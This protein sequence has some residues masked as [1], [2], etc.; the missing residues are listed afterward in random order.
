MLQAFKA[1]ISKEKLFLPGEKILLAVSGGMDSVAMAEL[2]FRAKFNFGIAHC[3]FQLR[4]EE[5]D[6]DEAFVSFLSRK[7]KVALYTKRF[8]TKELT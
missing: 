5:S 7:Y 1:Y 8:F 2:F 3:N 6:Q 4:G